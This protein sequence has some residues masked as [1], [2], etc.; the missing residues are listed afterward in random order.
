MPMNRPNMPKVG[1]QQVRAQRCTLP[2]QQA[3]KSVACALELRSSSPVRASSPHSQA[4][5][6]A[7]TFTEE[8]QPREFSQPHFCREDLKHE[9]Q[10]TLICDTKEEPGF[11]EQYTIDEQETSK[12]C[13]KIVNA[14]GK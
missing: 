10:A 6:I 4:Y 11:S 7:M 2:R 3:N 12:N 1:D 8:W 5:A 9:L 14:K 13:Q